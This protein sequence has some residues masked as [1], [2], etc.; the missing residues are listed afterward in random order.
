MPGHPHSTWSRE[1]SESGQLKKLGKA[2]G[3]T[4]DTATDVVASTGAEG[5][6]LQG[7]SIGKYV[8][9]F[10]S[11]FWLSPKTPPSWS[12]HLTS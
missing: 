8:L 4:G 6:V 9:W 7:D 11:P 1:S 12:L 10:Q 2:M 3:E 5:S